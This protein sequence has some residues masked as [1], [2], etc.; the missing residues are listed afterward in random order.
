MNTMLHEATENGDYSKVVSIIESGA[1]GINSPGKYGRT[2]LHVAAKSDSGKI[3]QLLLAHGADANIKNT[4]GFTSVYVA[5]VANNMAVMQVLLSS[6]V[7]ID[8]DSVDLGGMS[9]LIAATCN[10]CEISVIQCLLSAGASTILK[11]SIGRCAMD[12]ARE[13]HF[14]NIYALLQQHSQ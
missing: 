6:S 1:V 3:T 8:I 5:A 10:G 13:K 9:P 7:Y 11:D 2:A 14:R 4:H 12:W